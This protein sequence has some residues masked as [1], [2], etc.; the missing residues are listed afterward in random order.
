MR[1]CTWGVAIAVAIGMFGFY[2][3]IAVCQERKTDETGA[4]T[5]VQDEEF[6][7]PQVG[8]PFPNFPLVGLTETA[9]TPLQLASTET[10]PLV[11]VFVHEVTRPAFGLIRTISTY[12]AA[13]PEYVNAALVMLTDDMTETRRWAQAASRA[14][15]T[16]MLIAISPE[17]REGNGALGLNRKMTLTILV[18]KGQEITAN[19][20][21]VQ[22][23]DQGD[24]TRI[25]QAIAEAANLDAPTEEAIAALRGT[26][27]RPMTETEVDLRPLLAPVIR[28]DSNEQEIEA[29]AKKVEAEANANAA[30]RK[31][32]GD[33]CRTIVEGG[34]LENYGNE[35]SQTWLKQWADK[36]H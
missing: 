13:H 20:A 2:C 5:L 6:S 32:L 36:F 29:A 8:E 26:S 31:R 30:F 14:L 12:T 28:K 7:G 34:K 22:P 21:L 18:V 23:S 4:E 9:E 11:V 33:V 3:G 10:K 35:Y 24:A 17:G 16:D 27:A 19:F 25:C 15:P 1:E